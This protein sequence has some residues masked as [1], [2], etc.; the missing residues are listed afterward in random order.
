ME[1]TPLSEN[2]RAIPWHWIVLG[3]LVVVH[4]AFGG[5]IYSAILQRPDK[6]FFLMSLGFVLSHPI[7]FAIWAA[8]APQRFYH[9]F[10]WS[11][12]LCIL[13][14][15]TDG[16]GA[17]H[18]A[19]NDFGKLMAFE[20]ALFFLS[21]PILLLIRQLFGWNL[22][23]DSVAGTPTEEYQPYQFGIK[24][25]IILTTI[26]AI[27]LGLLRSSLVMA[28]GSFTNPLFLLVACAGIYLLLLLP[29]F[30]IPW[31]IL[32]VRIN[33]LLLIVNTIAVLGIC[34]RISYLMIQQYFLGLNAMKAITCFHI[35]SGLSVLSTTLVMRFCGFRMIRVPR[36]AS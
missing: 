25:L 10:F 33:H 30:I 19:E 16:I 29:V 11:F 3:L 18:Q 9:R 36:K 14:S 12:L 22:M 27:G 4:A 20:M 28:P 13:V 24:H 34:D 1:S 35:G 8:F 23:H 17:F 2:R 31:F 7:F 5:Y 26:T 15:F 6:P 32:P 21:F